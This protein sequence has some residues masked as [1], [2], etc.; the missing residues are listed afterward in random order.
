MDELRIPPAIQFVNYT[1]GTADLTLPG[2]A[3]YSEL[4]M[5]NSASFDAITAGD[6]GT[7]RLD[8][9]AGDVVPSIAAS[10]LSHAYKDD[11]ATGTIDGFNGDPLTTDTNGEI[12][13]RATATALATE[14]NN[15]Q[16]VMWPKS[17]QKI[18][19]LELAETSARLQWSGTQATAV[20]LLQRILPQPPSVLGAL[21]ADALDAIKRTKKSVFPKTESKKPYT[22]PYTEFMPYCV[23]V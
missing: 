19:K 10:A 18:S 12:A 4:C 2:R 21:A 17:M 15:V 16:A 3:L 23:K 22:G 8:L 14:P 5:L 20:I 6:F 7:I 1:A 9:G 13:N 11:F